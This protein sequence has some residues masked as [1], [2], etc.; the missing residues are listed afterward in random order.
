MLAAIAPCHIRRIHN[1]LDHETLRLHTRLRRLFVLWQPFVGCMCGQDA[2]SQK[3]IE[4]NKR[5]GGAIYVSF[6]IHVDA[7]RNATT[8]IMVTIMIFIIVGFA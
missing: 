4:G 8:R 7:T 5:G 2:C 3:F 1:Q 6:H